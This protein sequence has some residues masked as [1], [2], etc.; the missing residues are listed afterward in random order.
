MLMMLPPTSQLPACLPTCILPPSALGS[1]GAFL[2]PL[3]S[4][5]PPLPAPPPPAP[6]SSSVG[7]C[8]TS[9]TASSS[10]PTHGR[11]RSKG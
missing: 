2:L 11:Q 10:Q 5:P 1:T 6:A 4:P 8:I 7:L 9:H 3:V